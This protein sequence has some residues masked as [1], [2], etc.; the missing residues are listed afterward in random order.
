V[1]E[2]NAP[3]GLAFAFASLGLPCF[4]LASGRAAAKKQG[5]RPLKQKFNSK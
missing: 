1:W 2:A 5:N 3:Q 4:L